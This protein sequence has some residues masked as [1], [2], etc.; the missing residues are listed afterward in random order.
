MVMHTKNL[1]V[2]FNSTILTI[3]II[4]YLKVTLFI[5]EGQM[6]NY[7]QLYEIK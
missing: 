1:R 6:Q 7:I 4:L 2:C 3:L 5:Q